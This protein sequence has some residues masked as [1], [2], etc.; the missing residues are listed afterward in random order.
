MSKSKFDIFKS[1]DIF[2]SESV[3]IIKERV[4]R[5]VFVETG[6]IFKS[7]TCMQADIT[8]DNSV[9][10]YVFNNQNVYNILNR[11]LAKY[12]KKAEQVNK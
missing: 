6:N 9:N 1:F 8:D 3:N 12:R 2:N 10:L 11:S 5:L 4:I 7:T